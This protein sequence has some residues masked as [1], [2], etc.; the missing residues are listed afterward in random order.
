MLAQPWDEHRA[1]GPLLLTFRTGEGFLGHASSAL[2]TLQG[3]DPIEEQGWGGGSEP[4]D[5]MPG[6]GAG[7][8]A[9]R[10]SEARSIP[11]RLGLGTVA[12]PMELQVFVAAALIHG[13]SLWGGHIFPL[14]GACSG[15]GPLC[16]L[17]FCAEIAGPVLQIFNCHL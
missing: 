12:F 17:Q 3:L 8:P 7:V 10:A 1:Q 11:R 13:R 5:E 9:S 2:G 4:E 14:A 16:L 6:R 15:L